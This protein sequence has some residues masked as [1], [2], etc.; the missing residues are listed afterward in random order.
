MKKAVTI[1]LSLGVLGWIDSRKGCWSRSE[2]IETIL[3]GRIENDE[4]LYQ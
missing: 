4:M 2:Y 1:S 3:K